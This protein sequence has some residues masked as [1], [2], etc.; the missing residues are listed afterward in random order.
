MELLWLLRRQIWIVDLFGILLGAALAGQAT[1][2]LIAAALPHPAVAVRPAPPRSPA[3]APPADKSI[4]RIVGRNVFCSACGGPRAPAPTRHAYALLAIMI[5]PTD[6][7]WS[8]AIIRDYERLT[9][10]P[11]RVGAR[12]GDARIAVIDNTSVLLADGHG[13]SEILELL[14]RHAPTDRCDGPPDAIA[15]GIKKTGPHAYEVRRV[16]IDRLLSGGI[17][18]PWPRIV[19]ESRNDALAGFRVFGIGR[20]SPFAA[21]GLAN[22][23]LLLAVNGRSIATAEAAIAAFAPLRAASHVWLEVERDGRRVRLDYAIR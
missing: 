16:V 13:G 17:T 6:W 21:L 18:P 7:R 3:P 1:A 10:G 5:A 23:D 22:G 19:P 12:L 11:Y 8:V 2:N 4:D 9:V 15:D 20:D 14:E